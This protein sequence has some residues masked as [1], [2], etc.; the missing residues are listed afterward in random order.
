[1]NKITKEWSISFPS[2]FCTCARWENVLLTVWLLPPWLL[3]APWPLE[4][5][6]HLEKKK[7]KK[8]KVPEIHCSLSVI[9]FC[10]HSVRSWQ[11]Q[12]G[13]SWDQC[14]LPVCHRSEKK[15]RRHGFSCGIPR[16]PKP[17]GISWCPK[18][19]V[20]GRD[21]HQSS[22]PCAKYSPYLAYKF[23]TICYYLCFF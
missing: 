22:P 18:G 17:L 8:E 3:G 1:M 9:C 19:T 15:K 20:S 5:N 7:N 21:F 16:L 6:S 10:S 23:N 2:L 14:I 12:C 11:E 13:T 4:Q